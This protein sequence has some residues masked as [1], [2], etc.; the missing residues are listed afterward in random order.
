MD[1]AT[2]RHAGARRTGRTREMQTR[3]TPPERWRPTPRPGGAGPHRGGGL[4][5]PARQAH[6]S[7]T[8]GKVDHVPA[9][10]QISGGVSLC[11]FA[12]A[13][14]TFPPV[15]PAPPHE[16]PLFSQSRAERLRNRILVFSRGKL[17]GKRR[18]PG[19]HWMDPGQG[20]QTG[21][22]FPP[23]HWVPASRGPTNLHC[24]PFPSALGDDGVFQNQDRARPTELKSE[25]DRERSSSLRWSGCTEASLS[26]RQAPR[27]GRG[28]RRL[29]LW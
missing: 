27:G 2:R 18:F 4:A 3:T 12:P 10:L 21:L 19:A 25:P 9:F 6:M 20:A 14:S 29:S 13:K 28:A 23:H 5:F 8:T 16:L 1:A 24:A 7:I 26:L 17:P 22:F 11:T 15:I